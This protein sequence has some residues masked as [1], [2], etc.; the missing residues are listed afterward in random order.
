V[1][2]CKLRLPCRSGHRTVDMYGAESSEWWTTIWPV[3]LLMARASNRHSP[4]GPAHLL[5][6]PPSCQQGPHAPRSPASRLA[7]NTQAC[8]A[9]RPPAL[10]QL[11]M[12][13]RSC[14]ARGTCLTGSPAGAP[15]LTLLACACGA[16]QG[17]WLGSTLQKGPQLR[18]MCGA[19]LGRTASGAHGRSVYPQSTVHSPPSLRFPPRPPPPPL[20]SCTAY[21]YRQ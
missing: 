5:P 3:V 4:Y 2:G 14:G 20:S 13:R 16:S 12:Q 19:P 15:L 10:S 1:C 18:R 11:S 17:D 9:R 21:C 6:L 7:R 8:M